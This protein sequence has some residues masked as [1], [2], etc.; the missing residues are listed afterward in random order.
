M[1]RILLGIAIVPGLVLVSFFWV[2]FF[3]AQRA[4]YGWKPEVAH[5]SFRS[6]RP[7]LLFDEGHGN[8]GTLSFV[9]R[10]WPLAQLLRA[11]GYQLARSSK[12][13]TRELLQEARILA[14]INAS[15]A[16][17]PQAFGIN[18]PHQTKK[19]RSDPAFLPE[20]ISTIREWI[21]NGG[22]LL[23]VAD[24]AP[25]GE[26]V[27]ALA[28]SLGVVMHK[29]FVEVPNESSD[30]LVFSAENSRLGNHP[31]IA[32]SSPEN[33]LTRVMTYTGQS[34]DGPPEA[35]ILLQLPPTAIEFVPDGEA[36]KEEPAGQ[37][38][39]LAFERG[40]GRV[41]VLGEGGMLTAQVSKRVPYGMNTGDND[42]AMFV[43][44]VMRWLARD[45]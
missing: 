3:D 26:S 7:R 28:E 32:G 15:G 44:H 18:L 20:E 5:P 6:E 38:Q 39:G 36:M 1:K 23:F 22:S 12:P 21:E 37:A 41:V 43:R 9:G 35:T 40:R 25:F 11:D 42:N 30:P 8:A 31:I 27:S 16:A 17:K 34:L 10:Y 24:H 4:D 13:F 14:I 2:A 19:E 29:G 33:R 45:L